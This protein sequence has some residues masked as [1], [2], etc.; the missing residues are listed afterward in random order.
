MPMKPSMPALVTPVVPHAV[1]SGGSK[2]SAPCALSPANRVVVYVVPVD[3]VTDGMTVPWRLTAA[4]A[5]L[6]EYWT[7][8]VVPSD[9]CATAIPLVVLL[10]QLPL[11]VGTGSPFVPAK[12]VPL[13]GPA[14][15]DWQLDRVPVKL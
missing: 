10:P 3:E 1:G 11:P 13:A 12:T 5:P 7:T 9:H 8:V 6:V 14:D 4:R 2:A 15:E